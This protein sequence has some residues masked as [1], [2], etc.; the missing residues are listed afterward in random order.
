M[1]PH[2]LGVKLVI[3]ILS[4]LSLLSRVMNLTEDEMD[5]MLDR[6]FS[7]LS[8]EPCDE[9]GQAVAV[10]WTAVLFQCSLC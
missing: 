9:S 6:S 5:L 8:V 1:N 10:A 2:A 7:A 3:G 4:V